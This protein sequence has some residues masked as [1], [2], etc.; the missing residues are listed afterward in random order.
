MIYK[1][2]NYGVNL[3]HHAAFGYPNLRIYIRVGA[4]KTR[5][6]PNLYAKRV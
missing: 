3:A 6:A 5:L 4:R 2:T 1:T